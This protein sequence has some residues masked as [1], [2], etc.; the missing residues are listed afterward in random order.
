MFTEQ[1]L[2]YGT[3]QLLMTLNM[4]HFSLCNSQMFLLAEAGCPSALLLVHP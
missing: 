1:C 2:Y 3:E 4:S